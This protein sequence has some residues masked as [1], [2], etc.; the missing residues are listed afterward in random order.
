[1]YTE[2][3]RQWIRQHRNGVFGVNGSGPVEGFGVG[4]HAAQ[5]GLIPAQDADL[6]VRLPFR[7]GRGD[8]VDGAELE[9]EAAVVPRVAEQGG[10]RLAEGGNPAPDGGHW[11]AAR[12]LPLVV[13]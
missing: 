3:R 13:R 7:I 11:R 1:M 4:E 12:A 9:A 10:Q 8:L 6:E 5:P 2:Y